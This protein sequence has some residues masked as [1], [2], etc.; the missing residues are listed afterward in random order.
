MRKGITIERKDKVSYD[1]FFCGKKIGSIKRNAPRDWFTF[2]LDGSF[3]MSAL[4]RRQAIGFV[5]NAAKSRIYDEVM[6][7]RAKAKAERSLANR[8]A[9]VQALND[10]GITEPIDHLPEERQ[11]AAI[12]RALY[13]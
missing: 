7:I 6:S 9:E 12:K 5:D 8:C 3:I 2:R 13:F 11:I 4:N 10:I 1:V